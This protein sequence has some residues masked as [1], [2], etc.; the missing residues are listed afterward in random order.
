LLL[1]RRRLSMGLLTITKM[2][3]IVRDSLKKC[4]VLSFADSN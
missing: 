1:C 4:A 2:V 3:T